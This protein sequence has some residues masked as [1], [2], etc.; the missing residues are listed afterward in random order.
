MYSVSIIMGIL[1]LAL[2]SFAGASVWRLRARQLADDSKY[3]EVL[4]KKKKADLSAM[5]L[6]ELDELQSTKAARSADIKKLQPIIQP[7]AKDRSRCLH[8]H[9]ELAW[10]DLIPLVSWVN[11]KGKCRYCKKPIGTF[12]PLMELG[13]AAAFVLFYSWYSSVFY[14][15]PAFWPILVLWVVALTMLTILFAYDAKWYILPDRIVFPLIGVGAVIA[16]VTIV[17]LPNPLQALASTAGAVAILGGL[18]LV[19]WLVSR[20][21]WVGFGDVKLGV[22]LGLL[23]VDWKLA[24]LALF[25]ANLIGTLLVLPG[26]ITRKLDRKAHIPFGPLLIAGFFIALLYGTQLIQWYNELSMGIVSTMLML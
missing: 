21:Q 8:C 23:L 26:L 12:E 6:E 7:A 24:L 19:L 4:R 14:E 13:T 11:T 1:G 18:Y 16:T 22:A 20:G 2:G 17:T 5:E 9:H 25:L 10:Y 15:N 3:F